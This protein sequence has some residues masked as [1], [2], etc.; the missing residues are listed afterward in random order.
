MPAL[1]RCACFGLV[2][3][4]PLR[5]ALAS[6]MKLADLEQGSEITKCIKIT[7]FNTKTMT[8]DVEVADRLANG[9]CPTDYTYGT[10]AYS[11]SSN[12]YGRGMVICGYKDDGTVGSIS[13]G[14]NCNIGKCY[15]VK[16]D[17]TCKDNSKMTIN[18]CCPDNQWPDSCKKSGSGSSNSFKYC[19]SYQKV[20]SSWQ[21]TGTTDKTDDIKDGKLQV[22]KKRSYGWCGVGGGGSGSSTTGTNTSGAS[23]PTRVGFSAVLASGLLAWLHRI[24]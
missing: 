20:G 13:T 14:S 21:V 17:V 4:L 18:G 9:C 22:D 19:T 12:S 11:G 6:T 23:P 7:D 3:A 24:I 15:L 1:S 5:G 8:E 10:K 2:L 16:Q